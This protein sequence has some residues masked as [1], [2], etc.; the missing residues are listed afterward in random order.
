VSP[1]KG[2]ACK[3]MNLYLRWMVRDRDIDFGIWKGIPKDR[4]IIPLDTHIARIGK[5]LGLTVRSTADWKMAQEITRSLKRLDPVD[6]LKY[7][8]ALCHQGIAGVCSTQ[9]CADCRLFR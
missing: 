6:P 2:S 4:L 1:D 7:D 8:F 9:K 5:C 3:R